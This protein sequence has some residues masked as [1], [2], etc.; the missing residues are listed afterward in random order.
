ME[1]FEQE[2]ELNFCDEELPLSNVDFKTLNFVIFYLKHITENG[3]KTTKIKRLSN[4]DISF[5]NSIS[6][7]EYEFINKLEPE[8]INDLIKASNYMNIQSLLNLLCFKISKDF[9]KLIMTG[10]MEKVTRLFQ[11]KSNRSKEELTRVRQNQ[12]WIIPF[13]KK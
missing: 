9:T 11:I 2:E 4:K 5:K 13:I 10:D 12:N 6:S 7:W 8:I 3:N 1:E